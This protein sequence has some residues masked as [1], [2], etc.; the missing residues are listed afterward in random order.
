MTENTEECLIQFANLWQTSVYV[1]VGLLDAGGA[2]ILV[3]LVR[4][5]DRRRCLRMRIRLEK[6]GSKEGSGTYAD[7]SPSSFPGSVLS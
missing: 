5:D 2:V 4:R 6:E 7:R 1:S 3:T